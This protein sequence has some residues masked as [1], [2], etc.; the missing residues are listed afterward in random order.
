MALFPL[1]GPS[2]LVLVAPTTKSLVA[3]LSLLARSHILTCPSVHHPFMKLSSLKPLE[4][5]STSFW[6]SASRISPPQAQPLR[7][8]L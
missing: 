3:S 8:S 5:L 4:V 2:G 1:C 7:Q 6:V